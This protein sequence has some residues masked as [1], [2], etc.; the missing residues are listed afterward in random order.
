MIQPEQSA[1]S[2][3]GRWREFFLCIDLRS[4][5]LFRITLG[6][7]L[8][9]HGCMRWAW[10]DMLY[11]QEGALP[12]DVA[13]SIA[14]SAG[15]YEYFLSPLAWFDAPWAVRLYLAATL[16]CYVALVLG[17]RTRWAALL[18]WLAFVTW[19][20]RNP[21]VLIGA[22][23]VL[24]SMLLWAQFLPLGERF[25]CDALRR[26]LRDGVPLPEQPRG[27]NPPAVPAPRSMPPRLAA[28]G[29]VLQMA[30]IYLLTAVWKSGSTWIP[31]ATAVYYVLHVEQYVLAPGV[32]L[33]T[34]PLWVLQALTWWTLAV[35]YLAAPL[36]L[37]PWGQPHLRRLAL[38]MLVAL[39]VGIAAT[40][41]AGLF[42]YA[43]LGTF[44]LLLTARDWDLLRRLLQRWSPAATAYYD[45]S[46]GI[47]TRT[48]QILAA[49]DRFGRL[50]FVGSSQTG[51]WRHRIPPGLTE[52]TIVVFDDRTGRMTTRSAA[53]ARVLRALPWPWPLLAI[54]ALPGVRWVAD[55]VYDLVARNRHRLSSWLGLTA[56]RAAAWP[57]A[58]PEAA[59]P[60]TPSHDG[61]QLATSDLAPPASAATQVAGSDRDVSLP[62]GKRQR[63]T[64][65]DPGAPSALPSE[66]SPSVGSPAAPAAEPWQHRRRAWANNIA[67]AV[68]LLALLLSAACELALLD[69]RLPL[70]LRTFLVYRVAPWNF[71]VRG[72]LA[73][74][75][76]NMFAPDA[77][78]IDQWFVAAARL[79][80]GREED[81]FTQR[82]TTFE[83]PS[84]R[85]HRFPSTLAVYLKHAFAAGGPSRAAPL[86]EALCRCLARRWSAAHP[87]PHD[88]IHTVQL[89]WLR[90]SVADPWRRLPL[91]LDTINLGTWL[92]VDARYEPPPPRFHRVE[93]YP[94]GRRRAAGLIDLQNQWREGEWTFWREDGSLEEQGPFV[95]GL[96][97]GQ[98]I[99]WDPGG[100]KH[101]A[102]PFVRGN[103][104]G[105]WTRY[106]P[107]PP[108]Q[109][110]QPRE[111]QA[112]LLDGAAIGPAQYWYPWVQSPPGWSRQDGPPWKR[113]EH[114]DDLLLAEI[115]LA[116]LAAPPP[117]ATVR[118]AHLLGRRTAYG[119]LEHF[120]W[121]FWDRHGQP[122]PE[123]VYWHGLP[124]ATA[125]AAASP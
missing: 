45:D 54:I 86:A 6:L 123:V 111:V 66:T 49:L 34:L 98:W 55:R 23:F 9:A 101:S 102:G 117:L 17:Y 39:H 36:I 112:T 119:P 20:H 32:W 30:L 85:E 40:I 29:I 87:A 50:S 7:V 95:E 42:S 38:L 79:G 63:A 12:A 51:K 78:R 25:S 1:S 37:S 91:V 16:V 35:E 77:P 97:H 103:K 14:R 43:M 52:Q 56:C 83:Q 76:W 62:D 107:P 94:S 8:V 26:A 72:T 82:P 47:C 11:T 104:T 2:G 15:Y 19:A 93:W 70:P 60:D 67:A 33:R 74:Q 106:Y 121:Q 59:P 57:N 99:Y 61:E 122:L 48:C 41:D 28:L 58:R 84:W 68:V 64:P 21:F 44:P 109:S 116:P 73:V 81:L 46:C 89:L 88:A 5:G 118:I 96:P 4:L 92:A 3:C 69:A 65:H 125:S 90:R 18:S 24:A 53:V 115:L 10:L 80:D 108:G 71:V 110:F 22:D 120:R 114:R 27:D 75:R 124:Q 100:W 113:G 105:V 31:D 13:A